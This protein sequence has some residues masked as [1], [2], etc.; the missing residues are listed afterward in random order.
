MATSRTA[1]TPDDEPLSAADHAAINRALAEPGITLSADELA[2]L[3]AAGQVAEA[4]GAAKFNA[5]ERQHPFAQRDH[6]A[7]QRGS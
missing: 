5:F 2:A 7:R 4:L 3:L 1:P 6:I